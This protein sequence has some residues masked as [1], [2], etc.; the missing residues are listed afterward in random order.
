MFLQFQ[1]FKVF[2]FLRHFSLWWT[3]KPGR[4]WDP[5]QSRLPRELPPQPRLRLDRDG[6][7]GDEHHVHVRRDGPGAP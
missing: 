5:V 4:P 3:V 1:F 2:Y 7:P 6:V